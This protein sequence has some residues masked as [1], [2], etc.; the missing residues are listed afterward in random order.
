MTSPRSALVVALTGL[1][2]AGC[3]INV[4]DRPASPPVSAA[5]PQASSPTHDPR[6]NATLYMQRSEE[7]RRLSEQA[8]ALAT[9]R[10]GDALAKPGSAALE[11]S[12][13]GQG[14]PPAAIFDVDETVLDN[15][16]HQAR[17]I[18][19][20]K[21]E[22]DVGFWDE[23]V[24]ERAAT[25]MPGALD[26]VA[27]LR[28]RNIRVVFITNRECRPRANAPADPCPQIQDTLVNLK[29]VGFGD[30]AA[31]DLML[32][33]QNGWPSDKASRRMEVAKTH[34]II[35]SFGDQ[36]SDMMTVTRRQGPDERRTL[37]DAHAAMWGTRWIVIPNPSYGAWLDALPDPTTSALRTR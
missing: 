32:K 2:L 10:L 5:A 15:S 30:V 27:E 29:N 6:L 16:P 35:M 22:F 13:G 24:S 18:L 8:Y 33:G 37:S 28:R 1:L 20:G 26:F 3:S 31:S 17:A 14:K 9:L 34:R 11:Q 7:L 12:D 23:W 36:F 4:N 25:P 19:A 21:L